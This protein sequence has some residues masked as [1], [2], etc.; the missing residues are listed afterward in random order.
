VKNTGMRGWKENRVTGN[1]HCPRLPEA[2]T[3]GGRVNEVEEVSHS[4]RKCHGSS[5]VAHGRPGMLGRVRAEMSTI[6]MFCRETQSH[7]KGFKLIMFS[8]L[9]SEVRATVNISNYC[10]LAQFIKC[11]TIN[12]VKTIY[13][14]CQHLNN[15]C[16]TEYSL[17]RLENLALMT[18]L[19]KVFSLLGSLVRLLKIREA[20]ASR[21]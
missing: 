9:C 11:L 6:R 17:L 16:A 7:I 5:K 15:P 20:N 19:R 14:I 13:I 3:D 8:R 18:F 12:L 1:P 4:W 10:T 2:S 21:N